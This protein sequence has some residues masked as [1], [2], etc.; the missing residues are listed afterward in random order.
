M[1]DDLNNLKSQNVETT[2]PRTEFQFP[3]SDTAAMAKQF[4]E[5]REEIRFWIRSLVKVEPQ[6]MDPADVKGSLLHCLSALDHQADVTMQIVHAYRAT[7][8]SG[9]DLP[10]KSR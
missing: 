5:D 3:L 10:E 2:I 8:P 9:Y 7:L 4:Q 1:T 6:N